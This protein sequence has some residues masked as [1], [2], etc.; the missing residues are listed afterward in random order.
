MADPYMNPAA[1]DRGALPPLSNADLEQLL[2]SAGK[3]G[4]GYDRTRGFFLPPPPMKGAPS[5]PSRRTAM[6]NM[7]SAAQSG[8]MQRVREAS[9]RTGYPIALTR[10]EIMRLDE[11]TKFIGPDGLEH[12]RR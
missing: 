11:G 2:G 6:E 5:T 4:I 8:L 3:E 7:V 10:A 1:L 9:R 12:T